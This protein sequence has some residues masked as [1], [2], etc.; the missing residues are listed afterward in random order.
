MK[1]INS[2]A[3]ASSRTLALLALATALIFSAGC[4][5]LGNLTATEEVPVNVD[6]EQPVEPVATTN[7]PPLGPTPT[8]VP[9]DLV[10]MAS[11]EEQVFINVYER[12]NPAVVYIEISQLSGSTL[13]DLGSGSGFLI[14]SDG[15]IV[16]NQ[17]V[18]VDADQIR[19]VFSNGSIRP[20]EVVGTDPFAD[21]AVIQVEDVPEG[22]TP[23]EL[24]D[25]EQL[26]VGQRVIAIGNPFGLTGTMTIGIVSALGRTLPSSQANS[27]IGAFSNPEIIQ[28]DAAINPG[29]SG[30]PLLDSHGR[31][32]GVNTAIRSETGVNSGIGFAVPVNTVKRSVEQILETGAVSY[33]YLGISA[34]TNFTMTEIAGALGLPITEGVLITDVAPGSAAARAGLRG[35]NRTIEIRSIPVTVG[36]D[37]ITEIDGM[38]MH[39]FDD[40]LSYLVS[41]TRAGDM[42]TLTIYRDGDFTEVEVTLDERPQ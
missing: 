26:H 38:P 7:A 2:P 22:I 20:A 30:G 29:N 16:T 31:V 1:R 21:L 36:G 13:S 32:I 37:I 25:S 41:H 19:V 18:V 27:S 5:A 28:T 4:G 6:G 24:G 33:A 42:V 39:E 8:S 34:S 17:H 40:L 9:D 35:G 11:S 14:D 15:H 3:P 10:E 23:V 12:V